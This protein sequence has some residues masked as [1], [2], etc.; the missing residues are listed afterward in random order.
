MPTE[1]GKQF[2]LLGKM[3][4]TTVGAIITAIIEGEKRILLTRRAI[5][6]FKG[7]WC[8]PGGHIEKY[9]PVQ[10][11]IIREVKEEVGLEFQGQFF[12]AFDEILPDHEIHSVVIDIQWFS[13]DKALTLPLAF[14]HKDIISA[15]AKGNLL[16]R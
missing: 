14:A 9:E 3:P 15:Y 13:I 12:G 5:N 6:P 8:L 1:I 10:D 4:K 2:R 16:K 11:A 7:L